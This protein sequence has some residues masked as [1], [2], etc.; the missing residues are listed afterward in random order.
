[1][2]RVSRSA[3]WANDQAAALQRSDNLPAAHRGLC[4]QRSAVMASGRLLDAAERAALRY[5][6]S[7]ES[8]CGSAFV[9]QLQTTR[10]P[11]WSPT[12]KNMCNSCD[13]VLFIQARKYVLRDVGR[14]MASALGGIRRGAI[15]CRRNGTINR[16]ALL[17]T[18]SNATLRHLQVVAQRSNG[19]DPNAGVAAATHALQVVDLPHQPQL[20]TNGAQNT[21][22]QTAHCF[23]RPLKRRRRK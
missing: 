22:P 18:A 20:L 1:M 2:R 23:R 8:R 4:G 19:D 13:S 3:G 12:R 9:R 16:S 17:I 7:I 6:P 10:K 5:R 15:V 21:R 11:A 14:H